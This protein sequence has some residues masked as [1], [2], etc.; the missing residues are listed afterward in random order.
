MRF[1]NIVLAE[2]ETIVS[3]DAFA[4]KV[5]ARVAENYWMAYWGFTTMTDEDVVLR[6]DILLEEQAASLF[7]ALS[8]SG[9]PYGGK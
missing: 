3:G 8:N 7:H 6:G 1:R 4:L 9:L 5:V 2:P